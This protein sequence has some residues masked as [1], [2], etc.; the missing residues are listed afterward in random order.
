VRRH[1]VWA[2]RLFGRMASERVRADKMV[3]LLRA[4]VRLVRRHWGPAAAKYGVGMLTLWPL[5]RMAAWGLLRPFTGGRGRASLETWRS[6]WRRRVEW[7][8]AVEAA[9]GAPAAGAVGA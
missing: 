3:R 7:L 1:L 9:A 2:D 6:I 4:K 5:T 8:Q